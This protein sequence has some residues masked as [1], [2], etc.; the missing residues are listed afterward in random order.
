MKHRRAAMILTLILLL[1]LMVLPAGCGPAVRSLADQ[2]GM[3][4]TPAGSAAH[5]DA[6]GGYG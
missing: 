4:A 3:H 5:G 2:P 6:V 1:T